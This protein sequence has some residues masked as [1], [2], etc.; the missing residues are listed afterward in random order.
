M[1]SR[2]RT[3]DFFSVTEA[4]ASPYSKLELHH[5]TRQNCDKNY[6]GN[7]P[8]LNCRSDFYEPRR[9]AL[10]LCGEVA[11]LD[12]RKG[13]NEIRIESLNSDE[14]DEGPFSLYELGDPIV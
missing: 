11:L 14:V 4:R 7:F 9:A 3:A 10:R 8:S 2:F 13:F 6:F 5:D 1:K 12:P